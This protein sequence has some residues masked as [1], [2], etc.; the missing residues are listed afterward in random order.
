MKKLLWY[1]MAIVFTGMITLAGT[2]Y[3]GWFG[4]D[5]KATEAQESAAPMEEAAPPSAAAEEEALPGGEEIIL[6]GM[7]DE[8]N[9]FVADNGES[10]ELSSNEQGLEVMA[11]P[12]KKVEIRGTVME[13][14]GQKTVEVTNYSILE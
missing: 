9:K 7:I 14:E 1:T 2:S 12:G 5:K 11:L 8:S 6:S 13:E 3:A 4:S 10:Y